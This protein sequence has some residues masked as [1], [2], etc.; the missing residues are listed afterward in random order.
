[1]V[2][3]VGC[4]GAGKST[5][6]LLAAGLLPTTDGA[7]YLHGQRVAHPSVA[8]SI[9]F[10][11]YAL[12]PWR[13][14]IGNVAFPLEVLGFQRRARRERAS[15]ALA[16]V[17]L[18]GWEDRHIHEL[19]GGMRQ[20]VALARAVVTSP[21]VLLLD[22]PMSALDPITREHLAGEL[23]Q[24]F[25]QSGQTVLFV[26]HDVREAV[27]MGDRVVVFTGRPGRVV[28]DVTTSGDGD[29]SSAEAKVGR[30]LERVPPELSRPPSGLSG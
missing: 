13:T 28:G 12:L 1:V 6:L 20:R 4:S 30:L 3:I 11:D 23:R 7:I 27:R 17:G 19:S 15:A 5:L 8:T 16:H 14:A 10:Q 24:L 18:A 25:T 26:T 2:T 9:V 21:A 22:E 29:H